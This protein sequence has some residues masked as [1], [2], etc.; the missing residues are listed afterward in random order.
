LIRVVEHLS[1]RQRRCGTFKHMF[2]YTALLALLS[3]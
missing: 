1:D 2:E 3:S